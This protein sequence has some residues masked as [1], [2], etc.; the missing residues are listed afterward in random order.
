[1][2]R[3]DILKLG[4]GSLLAPL[5]SSMAFGQS[6]ASSASNASASPAGKLDGVVSYNAGWVI[7]LEDKAPL[8]EIEAR[9]TKEKE[10]GDRQKVGA[11][12]NKAGDAADKSKSFSG[13]FQE[14][15]GKIKGFF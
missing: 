4:V 5:I 13:K 8:L 6:N 10:E 9:K 1:M 2:K 3:R 14:L 7:P 11:S 15:L 12:S